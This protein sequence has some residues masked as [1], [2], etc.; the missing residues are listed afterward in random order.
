MQNRGLEG[1]SY[2]Q[3]HDAITRNSVRGTTPLP[4]KPKRQPRAEDP[5]TVSKRCSRLVLFRNYLV[6]ESVQVIIS[7]S[8]QAVA[9]SSCRFPATD[10]E[11]S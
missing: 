2:A 3:R 7:V 1:L 4:G 10:S 9:F 5:I 11:Q 6:P 8:L